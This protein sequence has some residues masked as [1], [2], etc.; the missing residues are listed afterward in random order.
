MRW[1]ELSPGF[2]CN[3]RCSGCFSCSADAEAQMDW[4]EVQRWLHYGRKKGAKHLW[5][6]GGEPTLRRDFLKTL[7]LAKHLGYERIK[8]QSNG[9]LFA[10]EG[11][12]E[13]ACAAGMNEVNLLLK[14][15]DPKVHDAL[16]RTP[17]S[18]ELLTKGLDRLREVSA[19]HPLR[20]EGD[21]LMTARNWQELP[22]LVEHYAKLGLVHF[23]IWLFSL[24]DQG[25]RDLRRLVP[26][27]SDCV[28]AMIA[29]RDVAKRLGATV[30]SLNTPQCMLPPT[31]WDMQFDAAGMD[32]AVVNPG[33][34][35]FM[36]ETS[37]IEQGIYVARCEG[38]A[39]RQ[40]CHGMRS[41]YVM[42]HGD[43][44]L[45]PVSAELALGYDPRGSI[46]DL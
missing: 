22:E 14:S 12:A 27:I 31:H 4:P 42:L 34:H 38:C 46:L 44:E 19:D 21:F 40:W 2:A 1:I 13:R 18:H 41:D 20:L 23:N 16:N 10:Y 7:R 9:M 11:F 26:R 8:V 43:E 32:L 29:A 5:L 25:S 37:S 6:S 3:C 45:Q 28:P 30:C 33:G 39:V 17:R 15:L 35:V 24:V 36:L